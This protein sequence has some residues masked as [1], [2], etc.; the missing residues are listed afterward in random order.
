M[1]YD[2]KV[3]TNTRVNHSA[4]DCPNTR[5][6][7]STSCRQSDIQNASLVTEESQGITKSWSQRA[8]DSKTSDRTHSDPVA[9]S[10]SGALED[11]HEEGLSP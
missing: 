3:L 1:K 4:N 7:R 2:N 9:E 10:F 5:G 8:E 11:T 6:P